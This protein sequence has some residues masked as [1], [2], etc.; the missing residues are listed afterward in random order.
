MNV[1]K[2]TMNVW[3]RIKLVSCK[4][5]LLFKLRHP[6]YS[7]LD[8]EEFEKD[9]IKLLKKY[10]LYDNKHSALQRAEIMVDVN[11]FPIVKLQ[12]LMMDRQKEGEK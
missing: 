7:I 12:T 9:V 5:K 10:N 1:R 6:Y 4:V 2:Q 8:K 11:D 3:K